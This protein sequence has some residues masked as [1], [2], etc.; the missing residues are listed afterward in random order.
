MLALLLALAPQAIATPALPVPGISFDLG[1]APK[2]P[3]PAPDEI[4]VTGTRENTRQR[5]DPELPKL[6]TDPDRLVL[7]IAGA[8]KAQI[9]TE[10]G[11]LGDGQVK[12][13]LTVPF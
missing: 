2:R 1:A 13:K 12:V 9:D 3:P 4:I 11:R 10:Q 7:G 6:K 8:A 5:L